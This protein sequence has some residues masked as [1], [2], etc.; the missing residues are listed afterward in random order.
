MVTL[1]KNTTNGTLY[2]QMQKHTDLTEAADNITALE[3]YVS[4]CQLQ[5][6]MPPLSY[7]K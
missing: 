2:V 7:V 4:H 6:M 3:K 1:H 5:E